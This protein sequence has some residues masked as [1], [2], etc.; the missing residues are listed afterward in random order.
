[1]SFST[2]QE[3]VLQL[4][5]EIQAILDD[6]FIKM[7]NQKS[8]VHITNNYGLIVLLKVAKKSVKVVNKML[9]NSND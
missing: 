5:N 9:S 8:L 1:M 7:D 2:R 6:S 4:I 3:Q